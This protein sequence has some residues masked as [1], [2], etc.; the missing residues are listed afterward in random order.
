MFVVEWGGG[1]AD[2]RDQR[3]LQLVDESVRLLTPRCFNFVLEEHT[4]TQMLVDQI[5]LHTSQKDPKVTEVEPLPPLPN[6]CTMD[7]WL[8]GT[9]AIATGLK[10]RN[11]VG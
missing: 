5:E 1:G 11:T 9:V 6:T 8:I 10:P 4:R 7:A 2:R 3:I